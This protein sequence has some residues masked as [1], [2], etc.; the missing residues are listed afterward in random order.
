MFTFCFF[1]PFFFLFFLT[2][3]DYDDPSCKDEA[4]DFKF[5]KWLIKEKVCVIIDGISDVVSLINYVSLNLCS[6]N[7]FM[8]RVWLQFLSV[9]FTVQSTAK[10]LTNTS[11]FVL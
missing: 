8:C 9:R 11:D 4:K 1:L 3:V 6:S 7:F 5:V 10:S 2:E